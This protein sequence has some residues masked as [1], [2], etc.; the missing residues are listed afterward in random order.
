MTLNSARVG[1]ERCVDVIV[2]YM[3]IKWERRGL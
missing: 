3:N 1:R 2:D